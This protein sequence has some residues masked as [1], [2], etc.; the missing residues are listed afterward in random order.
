MRLDSRDKQFAC[1]HQK[2]RDYEINLAYKILHLFL[3]LSARDVRITQW[4][5]I[6][7]STL[8]LTIIIQEDYTYLLTIKPFHNTVH[9]IRPADVYYVDGQRWFKVTLRQKFFKKMQDLCPV[10]KFRKAW[11]FFIYSVYIFKI[12]KSI[13]NFEVIILKA[14]IK[15]TVARLT[16]F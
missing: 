3:Y 7:H 8:S 15:S 5:S 14:F 11:L 4:S 10:A 2:R 13:Y 6:I 16:Q 12:Y 9:N 1:P